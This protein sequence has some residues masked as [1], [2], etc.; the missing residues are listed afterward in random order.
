MSS[1][2]TLL[3]DRTDAAETVNMTL[4]YAETAFRFLALLHADQEHPGHLGFE[5]VCHLCARALASVAER[6]GVQLEHLVSGL[7]KIQQEVDAK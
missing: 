5:A 1:P 7:R 4:S 2:N 6:E 3:K